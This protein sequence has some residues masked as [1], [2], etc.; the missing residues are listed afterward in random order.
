MI[1]LPQHLKVQEV[2]KDDIFASLDPECFAA[3]YFLL[4]GAISVLEAHQA[5]SRLLV[6][7][8]LR[9][10]QLVDVEVH[11]AAGRLIKCHDHVELCILEDG[12]ILHRLR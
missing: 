3:D 12:W 11:E 4:G 1:G 5:R 7:A 9:Q 6:V 10:Q 2:V 8:L